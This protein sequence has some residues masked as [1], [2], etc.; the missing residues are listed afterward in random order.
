V[1]SFAYIPPFLFRSFAVLGC[2]V[3][4]I[5]ISEKHCVEKT[6]P[7]FWDALQTELGV[8]VRVPTEAEMRP[9][10]VN[11]SVCECAVESSW[12]FAHKGCEAQGPDKRSPSHAH[13][14]DMHFHF[15]PSRSNKDFVS[16]Q[17]VLSR[18]K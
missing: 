4:G 5:V 7:Q 17:Y 14:A 9:A 18:S 16:K 13:A 15:C 6:Y 11:G 12:C 3:P 1:H 2:A 8:A 10:A